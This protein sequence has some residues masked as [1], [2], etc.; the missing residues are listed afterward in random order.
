MSLGISFPSLQPFWAWGSGNLGNGGV[1][2]K[3]ALVVPRAASVMPVWL[4]AWWAGP[5]VVGVWEGVRGCWESAA[6]G[7]WSAGTGLWVWLLCEWCT[8]RV[9]VRWLRFFPLSFFFFFFFF[10]L[11]SS[12]QRNPPLQQQGNIFEKLP[13]GWIMYC[14]NSSVLLIL[15]GLVTNTSYWGGLGSGW[16]LGGQ[17]CLFFW[18]HCERDASQKH[19]GENK[20]CR[21]SLRLCIQHSPSTQVFWLY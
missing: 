12:R 9:I 16:N 2:G 15:Q 17:I 11:I 21:V 8:V 1:W 14:L 13:R 20:T 3:E 18:F 5:E 10:L 6:C 4:S 19:P 7:C